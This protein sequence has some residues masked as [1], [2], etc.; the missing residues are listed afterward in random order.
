MRKLFYVG[1]ALLCITLVASCDKSGKGGSKELGSLEGKWQMK[2]EQK[3]EK[4]SFEVT[5]DLEL[6][7]D[8]TMSANVNSMMQGGDN[9]I[10][11]QIPMNIS[12]KG[13]WNTTDDKLEIKADSATTKITMDKDKVV[14]K[15]DDPAIEKKLGAFKELLIQSVESPDKDSYEMS[16][17]YTFQEALPYKLD[18]NKLLLFLEKDTLVFEKK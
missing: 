12:Y 8:K 6:K 15:A 17:K 18:G 14:F 5:Y 11:M 13:T 10:T 3:E 16:R 9:G 4:G 2:K 1:I 7:T